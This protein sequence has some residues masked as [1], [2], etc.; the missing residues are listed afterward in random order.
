M[1]YLVD[2]NIFLHAIQDKIYS[3]AY[4]CKEQKS[5]IAITQV[6]LDELMPGNDKLE[7]DSSVKDP[8]VEVDNLVTGKM[9][10]KLIRLIDIDSIP[11]AREEYNKIRKRFYSWMSDATFLKSLVDAGT[12]TPTDIKKSSFRNKDK[13]ECELIAIAKTSPSDYE[14]V[15]NDQGKV[16][17]HPSQ[18]L[19]ADY[20][21]PE[22]ITVLSSENWLK[23]VYPAT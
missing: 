11:G 12:Y 3:V 5:E 6:I 18:N 9:G 19:F 16:F 17:L 10:C 8:Y 13:G 1:Y 23:L 14:I 15:S 20:A 7:S 2:T 4:A 22:G 21:I